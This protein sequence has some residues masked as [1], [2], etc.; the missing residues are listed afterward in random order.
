[1][2][3]TIIV[4]LLGLL[5]FCGYLLY[6]QGALPGTVR[7]RPASSAAKDIYY[8]PMHPQETSDKPGECPICHMSLIKRVTE[9]PAA[10]TSAAGE[11]KILYYRNPMNPQVTSPTPMKDEMGMDYI[12]VYE[13]PAETQNLFYVSSAR[14]QLIG[15]Q[16]ATVDKRELSGRILTVGRVAYDP[17]LYVAQEEYL[18]AAKGGRDGASLADAAK[19]KLLLMGMSEKEISGLRS[20]GKPEEGL[21]LPGR[22]QK[23]VWV[24]MTIYEYESAFVKEGQPVEVSSSAF[25]GEVFKGKVVSVAPMLENMTRSLKVRVQVDNP[26]SR[27]KLE[28]Y[29]NVSLDYSLGTRLA[30]PEQAVMNTGTRTYVFKVQE[31]GHFKPCDVRLGS[32]AGG[33]YEVLSGLSQ[34]DEIVTSGNFLLDS[35][36]KLNAALSTMSEPNATPAEQP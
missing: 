9:A 1:M 20:S 15:V 4:I 7:P 26:K 33:Y 36:S 13:E 25:P 29:V 11:R 12:P 8:C 17:D 5:A 3:N 19:R 34:G 16:T 32:K 27:L 35:E 23:K 30:V 22:D 21:Y 10:A 14:Q 2:K 18:Q 6:K 31:P 24:Y 28:M